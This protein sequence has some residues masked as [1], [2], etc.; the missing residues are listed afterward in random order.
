MSPGGCCGV[1][2]YATT[3]KPEGAP[4][5]PAANTSESLPPRSP[6]CAKRLSDACTR[7][8]TAYGSALKPVFD[9]ERDAASAIEEWS[10]TM[11]DMEIGVNEAAAVAGLANTYRRAPASDDVVQSWATDAMSQVRQRYGADADRRLADAQRL[12]ARDPRVA[13]FLM[14]SG[15]GSHPKVVMTAIERAASLRAAGRLK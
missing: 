10:E 9:G 6:N 14:Q 12:V 2:V 8:S 5:S 1:R 13:D 11:A 7:A 4:A 3:A 15:L